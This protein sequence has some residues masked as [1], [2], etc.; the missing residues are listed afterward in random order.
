M[1]TVGCVVVLKDGMIVGWKANVNMTHH[2]RYL[3]DHYYLGFKPSECEL[4]YASFQALSNS[5]A[6]EK[7]A[8]YMK[9]F[10]IHPKA[11]ALIDE[12]KMLPP[13]DTDL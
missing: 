10:S 8:E 9:Q 3:S 2:P 5:G 4:R 6:F 12:G 13:Y 7:A 1:E 11:Q